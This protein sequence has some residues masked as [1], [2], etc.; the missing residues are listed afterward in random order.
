ML[1]V[2]VAF[3][4]LEEVQFVRRLL[5]LPI[6]NTLVLVGSLFLIFKLVPDLKVHTK[7]A[8]ISSFTTGAVLFGVHKGYGLLA[9]KAFNYSSIYGSF[10]AIPLLFLWMLSIWYVILAGVAFCA[11]LQK[12]HMA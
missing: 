11:G 9:Q 2:Y 10:A 6:S 8:V 7:A 3:N 12:R 5:P 1:A 4:S